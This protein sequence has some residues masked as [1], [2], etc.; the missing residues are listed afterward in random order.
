MNILLIGCLVG[1]LGIVIIIIVTMRLD[2]KRMEAD[3][4]FYIND[5]LRIQKRNKK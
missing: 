2:N 5:A 3:L 1:T 4:D